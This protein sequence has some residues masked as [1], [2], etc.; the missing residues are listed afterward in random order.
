[1]KIHP[2]HNRVIVRREEDVEKS[3]GGI[4]LAG[5]AKEKPN[6]GKIVAVGSGEVLKS[7]KVRDLDVKV[8]DVVVFG[9]YAGNNVIKIDDE[10]L[11][12][13]QEKEIF[14]VVD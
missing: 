7:G 2:L 6:K 4:I 10:E 9:Q 3:A 1:M 11:I 5:S 12:I 8:G 13:L 14:A